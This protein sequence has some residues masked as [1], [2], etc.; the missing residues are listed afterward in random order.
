MTTATLDKPTSCGLVNLA[1]ARFAAHGEFNELWVFDPVVGV[2]GIE[3]ERRDALVFERARDKLPARPFVLGCR[4]IVDGERVVRPPDAAA[5]D[6][7][8]DATPFARTVPSSS[9]ASSKAIIW[10]GK[11][12]SPPSA[13]KSTSDCTPSI[14]W[15][16]PIISKNVSASCRITFPDFAGS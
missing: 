11:R 13:K 1:R 8:P 6:T 7:D 12:L 4:G 3:L 16:F 5:R 9:A 14:G 10:P 15:M 2:V